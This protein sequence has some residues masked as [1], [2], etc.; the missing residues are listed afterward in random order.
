MPPALPN[1]AD[2]FRVTLL[3][4]VAG[5]LGDAAFGLNLARGL[6]CGTAPPGACGVEV[7]V[8]LRNAL[9]GDDLPGVTQWLL[10]ELQASPHA[11]ITLWVLGR[12]G[13]LT[14]VCADED[15]A[16]PQPD[17]LVQAP[18]FVYNSVEEAMAALGL[19]RPPPAGLLTVREFGHGSFASLLP[20]SPGCRDVSSG[21][22]AG[23]L[24]LF[25]VGP[26][27]GCAPL[28]PGSHFVGHIRS[29]KGLRLL[30]RSVAAL[31]PPGLPLHVWWS[32]ACGDAD[33]LTAE[34]KR[35]GWSVEEG[36]ACGPDWPAPVPLLL[37]D[38]AGAPLP[39]AAFRHLLSHCDA[40]VVSGDQSLNE[41]R[42][43][44]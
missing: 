25:T 39:S 16:P 13:R 7:A 6:V 4:S 2:P 44:S 32:S 18:L 15:A 21:L 31:A 42:G 30:C 43:V 12:E 9:G 41:V 33:A 14:R 27:S 1:L 11:A 26:P 37:H 23:E 40:A 36:E 3:T 20:P 8:V 19:A 38:L 35:A 24:G 5:G 28:P 10:Q 17:V 22:C 34:L 29:V